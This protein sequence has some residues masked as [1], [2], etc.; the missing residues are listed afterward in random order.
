MTTIPLP[1]GQPPSTEEEYLKVGGNTS[2]QSLASAVAHAIYAGRKPVLRAVGAGA[3]NQAVKAVAIAR[4]YVA[5]QGF[6]LTMR[7]GFMNVDGEDTDPRTQKPVQ[8]SAVTLQ[9]ISS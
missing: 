8:I 2:A 4:G 9:V 7:P 3:V 5:P 1:P 6:D